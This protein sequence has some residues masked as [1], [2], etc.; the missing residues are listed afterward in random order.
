MGSRHAIFRAPAHPYTHELLAAVPVADPARARR[1][2]AVPVPTD[3][4]AE[5]APEVGCPYQHRCL[6]R[7]GRSICAEEMPPLRPREQRHLVACHFSEELTAE[8]DASRKET[9]T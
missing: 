3:P 4:V 2:R 1:R 9:K 6:L 8:A 5:G 7:R